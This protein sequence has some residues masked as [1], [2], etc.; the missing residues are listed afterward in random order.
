MAKTNEL[1]YEVLSQ[2]LRLL[3]NDKTIL[4]GLYN[5][6]DVREELYKIKDLDNSKAFITTKKQ[7]KKT[8][9]IGITTTMNYIIHLIRQYIGTTKDEKNWKIGYTNSK[10]EVKYNLQISKDKSNVTNYNI[11]EFMQELSESY[12][13]SSYLTD[14]EQ[15][16]ITQLLKKAKNKI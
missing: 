7:K 12:L 5:K 15:S 14:K 9:D 6:K 2:A 3:E 10:H 1:N 8:I 13:L 11:I 4:P 16:R